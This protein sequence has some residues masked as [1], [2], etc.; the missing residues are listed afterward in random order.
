[1]AGV[2]Q[3]KKADG[4]PDWPRIGELVG[5]SNLAVLQRWKLTLD[6][7]VANLTTGP[8]SA[9]EVSI[10]YCCDMK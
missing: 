2:E 6:P 4:K 5:R 7:K 9:R 10:V 8:F 3:Y 1:M